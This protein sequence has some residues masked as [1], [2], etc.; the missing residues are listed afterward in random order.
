[1]SLIA[2]T[3]WEMIEETDPVTG[4]DRK[5]PP[6]QEEVCQ[7]LT[8]RGQRLSTRKLQEIVKGAG[9]RWPPPRTDDA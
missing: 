3:Y 2:E 4:S 7:R 8:D 6:R 9:E 1:M 5:Y